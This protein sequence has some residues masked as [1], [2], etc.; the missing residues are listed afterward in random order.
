MFYLYETSRYK[1]IW[2]C[3][4]LQ[5]IIQACQQKWEEDAA[6]CAPGMYAVACHEMKTWE[7]E[8]VLRDFK[9]DP[10]KLL[11][12]LNYGLFGMMQDC[13]SDTDHV[14]YDGKFVVLEDTQYSLDEFGTTYYVMEKTEGNEWK[15]IR[16]F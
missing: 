1:D 15:V 2:S 5:D 3:D 7:H 16:R 14:I 4:K 6:E 11:F 8:F 9:F 12:V 13:A 10:K